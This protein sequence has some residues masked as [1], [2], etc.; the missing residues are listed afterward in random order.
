MLPPKMASKPTM[1]MLLEQ[2]GYT[3]E[4]LDSMDIEDLHEAYTKCV[5]QFINVFISNENKENLKISSL[6]DFEHITS[7]KQ[8]L[9]SSLNN[10]S[11]LIQALLEGY[12]EFSYQEINDILVAITKNQS[13]HKIQRISRIAYR[14]FQE[15]L[16]SQINDHIKELPVQEFI[17]LR[18]YYE[19]ERENLALLNET[20]HKLI[21]PSTKQQVFIM[22]RTKLLI[23][24]DFM[25]DLMYATYKDYYDNTAEKLELVAKIM[26]LTGLYT[27]N[28]LKSIPLENL[29]EMH[30][31]MLEYNRQNDQ[32][33]KIFL[34]YSRAIQESIYSN[35]DDAFNEVCSRAITHLTNKQLT[36][37]T[38]YM[39]GQ[40][41]FF[42][43]KFESAMN[44]YKKKMNIK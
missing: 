6:I 38:E 36:M 27:K 26:T 24:Q 39:V 29:Q 16:L 11:S 30:Q 2:Y 10:V 15:I 42:L 1:I 43:S 12:K 18:D 4:S 5:R 44:E 7:Y 33:R 21:D 23:I 28:Y 14:Q 32:D 20:I 9:K 40:N 35:D 31:E 34:K 3:K 41:P 25:P 8:K 17:M 13:A 22:A 19:K 37:F